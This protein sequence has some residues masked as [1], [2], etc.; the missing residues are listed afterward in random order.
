MYNIL[1]WK[2]EYLNLTGSSSPDEVIKFSS[3][4][5]IFPAAQWPWSLLNLLQKWVPEDL[6]GGKARMVRR[7]DK[8]TAVSSS[9]VQKLWDP[10]HLTTL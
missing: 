4:Y 1:P 10:W 7:A 9:T 5:L 3:I 2:Q 6:S 8:F